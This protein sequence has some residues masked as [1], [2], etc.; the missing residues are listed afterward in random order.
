MPFLFF[1]KGHS[2]I[3]LFIFL[4]AIAIVLFKL[5]ALSVW[6]SVLSIAL[7]F[8]AVVAAATAI[9]ALWKRLKSRTTEFIALRKR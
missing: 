5:G 2:M 3:F 6:F 7:I 8:I 4:A 1:H 9:Y